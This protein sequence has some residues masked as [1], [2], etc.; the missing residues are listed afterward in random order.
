MGKKPQRRRVAQWGGTQ[1]NKGTRT[2]WDARSSFSTISNPMLALGSFRQGLWAYL[3][4]SKMTTSMLNNDS[5][6]QKC[7]L[8]LFPKSSPLS[9]ISS[10][11]YLSKSFQQMAFRLAHTDFSSCINAPEHLRTKLL[12]DAQWCVYMC[13]SSESTVILPDIESVS[14]RLHLSSQ[15]QKKEENFNVI[16]L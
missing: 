11:I 13:M 5:S 9:L 6:R 3:G 14:H 16:L 1:E 8:G 12:D 7:S 10:F 4:A 15:R 2:F